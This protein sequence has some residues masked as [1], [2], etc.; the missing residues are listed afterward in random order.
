MRFHTQH[1]T[2][3]HQTWD[4]GWYARLWAGVPG[5]GEM[6]IDDIRFAPKNAMVT[7]TYYDSKWRQPI[8]SVDANNKPS[9][10]VVYDN[11]G[12][13]IEWYRIDPVTMVKHIKQKKEYHL[14]GE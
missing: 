10:Q 9:Q 4:P 6:W 12:R 2:F 11:W 7:T 5:G 1:L 14:M 13:P 8:M 3:T